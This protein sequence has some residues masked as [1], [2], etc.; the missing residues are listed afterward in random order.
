[1][2]RWRPLAGAVVLDVGGGPGWFR[3]A[4]RSRG[5]VYLAVE[6]DAGELAGLGEPGSGAV[7]A[8]GLAL[9]IRAASVDVSF[10]S[11]VLE[12]VPDPERFADEL[13]RVTRA[14]GT[15]FLG[16]TPWLSPWGGHETSPF[17][18]LGGHRARRRYQARHGHPPKNVFGRSL[19]SVSVSRMLRWARSADAEL[20]AVLARY[21]PWWAQ[22]LTRLPLVREVAT[23][24]VVLVLRPR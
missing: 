15:V 14:G 7:Q 9:P 3:D 17:H 18:Y 2:S 23:W 1:M 8:S 6:S 21:H 20:V 24:N 19:Y 11:N 5:A 13:V 4:F 12:H 22:W 10:S 16:F